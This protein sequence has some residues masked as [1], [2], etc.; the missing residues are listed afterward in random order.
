MSIHPLANV[1]GDCISKSNSF[2]SPAC[3]V[4]TAG[5]VEYVYHR[6]ALKFLAKIQSRAAA[7]LVESFYFPALS[8]I[9]FGMADK[10]PALKGVLLNAALNYAKMLQ[11]LE[12][13]GEE[14][15]AGLENLTQVTITLLRSSSLKPL[16]CSM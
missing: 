6:R 13:Y 1:F 5:K 3:R 12:L 4:R 11:P 2:L 16:I 14:Q 15:A 9:A 7:M 8:A 10:D